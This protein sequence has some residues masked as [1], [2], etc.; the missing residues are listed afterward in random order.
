MLTR[1]GLAAKVDVIRNRFF[2]CD[3]GELTYYHRHARDPLGASAACLVARIITK[4]FYIG[5]VAEAENLGS[6]VTGS[7]A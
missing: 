7:A 4:E 3:A 6:C 1:L 2:G 5:Y